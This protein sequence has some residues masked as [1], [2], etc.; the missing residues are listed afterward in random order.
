MWLATYKL[1]KLDT[2][3]RNGLYPCEKAAIL[4]CETVGRIA[5]PLPATLAS[6]YPY[7]RPA[8]NSRNTPRI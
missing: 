6:Q 4:D 7:F 3:F 5:A 8:K 2:Y 1:D